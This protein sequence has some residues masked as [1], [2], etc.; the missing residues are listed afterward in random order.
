M[1]EDQRLW[2]FEEKFFSDC[3]DPEAEGSMILLNV[4]NYS[5]NPTSY[6]RSAQWCTQ[7]LFSGRGQQIQ[8]RIEGGESGD[9]GAVAP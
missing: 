2:G 1:T 3:F 8:L 6:H 5:Q 7:E 4:R 9:L